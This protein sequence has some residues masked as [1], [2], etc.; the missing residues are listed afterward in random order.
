QIPAFNF[1]CA[2]LESISAIEDTWERV[3][4]GFAGRE[5]WDDIQVVTGFVG[6]GKEGF[7]GK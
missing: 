2:S 6:G 1:I 4:S 7:L 3:S 5:V